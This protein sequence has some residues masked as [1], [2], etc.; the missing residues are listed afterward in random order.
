MPYFETYIPSITHLSTQSP[1][2]SIQGRIIPQNNFERN[3]ENSFL[4]TA[5]ESKKLSSW[6]VRSGNVIIENS[7]ALAF[8]ID[9]L[10]KELKGLW[11]SN[12]TMR[13]IHH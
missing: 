7:L 12:M 9:K 8:E 3:N 1:P 4:V 2:R 6:L 11:S 5:E 10:Q 13:V